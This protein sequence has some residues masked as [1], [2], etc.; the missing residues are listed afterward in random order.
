ML[1]KANVLVDNVFMLGLNVKDTDSPPI[2]LYGDSDIGE[3]KNKAEGTV[4]EEELKSV[5]K[6]YNLRD[7]LIALGKASNFVLNAKGEGSIGKAAFRDPKTGVFITQFGLAYLANILIISGANDYKSKYI[8]KKQNLLLLLNIYSNCL[9]FPEIKRDR[10]ISFTKK[11]LTS[12]MVRMHAE[13]FEYQF[14]TVLLIARTIVIFTETVNQVAPKRF[15]PLATIFEQETGLT[16]EEYFFLAMAV[17]ACVQ[18]TATFRKESLTGAQI[19]SMQKVLTDEKITSFLKIL[20]ADYQ[21]FRTE[22]Q[23]TN[24]TLDPVFT[25]F[26]F[27][28]LLV[29]PIIKT[30]RSEIDPYI[31]PNA[32]AFVKKAF[33]G[34]YWWFHRYFESSGNWHDFRDYYGQIFEQY[35][36]QIL[37]QTYGEVNVH[38]EI[39]YNN[40]KFIDWWVEHNSKIYLF[41]A[42]AYQF[43]LFTKQTGDLELLVKEVKS[44]I[45]QTIEQVYKRLQDIQKY[46]ELSIFRG[47][48]LIPVIVFMEIP[49]ASGNLYKEIVDEELEQL[50]KSGLKG[51][52]E[53]K[54]HFLNI[55]ELEFYDSAVDKIPLEEAF[56]Q[57]ENNIKEG[58]LSVIGKEVNKQL[59]NKYL[60]EVY[61]S[62]WKKM[63]G[64]DFQD[65]GNKNDND[66]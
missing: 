15:A 1:Y 23:R 34:L 63:T 21:T 41:E 62:F 55:E 60:D 47:K 12:M 11:D 64:Q 50:E 58:F 48:K 44:K 2:I 65:L 57:Y 51:I 29:Y 39:K 56:A 45:V 66:A 54:I 7:G 19:Q 6:R 5:L 27:N 20:S 22:D 30:D 38:P 43:A 53:A 25:K 32:L 46:D 17:W 59:R 36:G 13:Q 4:T 52:K 35:V 10:D 49:L 26:R 18:Q 33:G 3:L 9:I 16:F 61:Y 40:G 28:P 31:V 37:K 14:N 42:K 8:G 24:D